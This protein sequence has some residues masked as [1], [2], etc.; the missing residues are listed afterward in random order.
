MLL[1][2][3]ITVDDDD[4]DGSVGARDVTD[5]VDGDADDVGLNA[6]LVAA[7][8]DAEVATL[9]PPVAPRVGAQLHVHSVH[10]VYSFIFAPKVLNSLGLKY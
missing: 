10:R 9:A 5:D 2:C 8:A 6:T 3:Y 7:S 4:S 1:T